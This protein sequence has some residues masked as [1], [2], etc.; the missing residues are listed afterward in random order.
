MDTEQQ[1]TRSKF[2]GV[3]VIGFT[4]FLFCFC[5]NI[6]YDIIGYP[7]GGEYVW[8]FILTLIIFS[9]VVAVITAIKKA[10]KGD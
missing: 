5:W 9:I 7:R 10:F 1:K 6:A 2:G 4:I 3:V 8:C